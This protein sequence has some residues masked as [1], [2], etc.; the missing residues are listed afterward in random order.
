MTSD[1][2][3]HAAVPTWDVTDRMRKAL[4]TADLGALEMAD[5]LGVSRTS[6]SSWINGRIRPSTA[7]LRL[8]AIRCGVDFDWLRSGPDV[9]RPGFC[10]PLGLAIATT[11]RSNR[12]LA[13]AA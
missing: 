8:W 6:V 13:A 11:G 2:E 12:P 4:R 3:Q 5:Y 1:M 9:R 7:I 10:R